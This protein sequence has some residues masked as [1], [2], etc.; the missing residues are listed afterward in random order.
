MRH[1]RRPQTPLVTG[2][3]HIIILCC[4]IPWRGGRQIGNR[5]QAGSLA[6]TATTQQKQLLLPRALLLPSFSTCRAVGGR[7]AQGTL[8]EAA[9]RAA[10]GYALFQPLPREVCTTQTCGANLLHPLCLG[11]QQHQQRKGIYRQSKQLVSKV[12]CA[13][14]DQALP[15]LA[16]AHSYPTY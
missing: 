7:A 15:N 10:E 11:V 4:T 14:C 12:L 2:S 8:Q 16:A 5:G 3:H 9:R 1:T 13:F 6:S